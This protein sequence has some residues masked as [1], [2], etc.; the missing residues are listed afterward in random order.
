M[1]LWPHASA[2]QEVSKSKHVEHAYS[3]FVDVGPI[4]DASSA[5]HRLYICTASHQ[6]YTKLSAMTDVLYAYRPVANLSPP[7]T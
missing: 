2:F 6:T 7:R 5:G 3:D 4:G 1:G